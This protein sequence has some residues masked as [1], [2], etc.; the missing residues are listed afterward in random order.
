MLENNHLALSLTEVLL[1][2]GVRV[3]PTRWR[4][5]LIQYI[6]F[7]LYLE[8]THNN[9]PEQ[10][11]ANHVNICPKAGIEHVTSCIHSTNKLFT[12]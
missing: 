11:F 8:N 12:S 7:S 2:L 9:I 1:S 5:Y 10:I 4:I 3:I 6:T